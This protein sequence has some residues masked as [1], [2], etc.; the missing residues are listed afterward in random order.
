M[1]SYYATAQNHAGGKLLM[2]KLGKLTLKTVG[3][4][5]GAGAALI[6]SWE[7]TKALWRYGSKK[8]AEKKA[9]ADYAAVAAVAAQANPV[10]P[11]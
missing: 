3:I 1:K 6:A 11:Q 4:G 8:R 10:P 2:F 5:I 7:G 9:A